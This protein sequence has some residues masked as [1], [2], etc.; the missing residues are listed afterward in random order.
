MTTSTHEAKPDA[1]LKRTALF[2][3]VLSSF[4]TPFMGSSVNIALPTIGRRFE[5]DA[6]L[7]SWVSSAYLLA[8]AISLVPVGKLA[9]SHGRKRVFTCGI[10]LDILSSV[11]A[12]SAPSSSVLIVARFLQ[13]VGGAMIFGTSIAIL[14][15]VFAPGDRGRVLGCTVASVYTGL[16]LGPVLGGLLVETFGWRTVF[17]SYLPFQAIVFYLALCRLEGEWAESRGDKFD[18]VGAAIYG[19]SLILCMLGLSGLSEVK[20]AGLLCLGVIATVCFVRWETAQQYPVLEMKL[21]RGNRAFAFSNLAAFLHYSATFAVGFLLS[22]Y[23][24]Y[25]KGMNAEHAGRVLIAQ[26]IMMALFSPVAGR[27]SDRV[28]PRLVASTGMAFTVAGLSLL[29][30]LTFQ[31]SQCYIVC[32]LLLLGF[33]FA[34]FSSPNSNAI[35]SSVD[36]RFYGVAAGLLST[37][38]VTGQMF[39]MGVSVL[40][41]AL[42]IGAQKITPATYPHLM[43]STRVLFGIFTVLCFG[44]IFASL[45]RGDVR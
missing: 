7:L 24:Q 29:L 32:C 44:G 11:L 33:G 45:S 12:A 27:L 41:F 6:V 42:I 21:F 34:L 25:I 35:M 10:A 3:A 38:R 9:D 16:S 26:P 18:L 14:T 30:R 2:V 37:M 31:S 39:S 17:L 4:L 23:L 5:M 20:G 28:E 22:L 40:V 43:Q 36:R 19:V 13:G 15:S 8:A 1:R